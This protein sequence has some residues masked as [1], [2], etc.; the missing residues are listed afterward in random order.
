[1]SVR[2]DFQPRSGW[3]GTEAGSAIEA[4]YAVHGTRAQQEISPS[5]FCPHGAVGNQN[6]RHQ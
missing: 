4:E 5:V 3:V 2:R 6:G 1:M